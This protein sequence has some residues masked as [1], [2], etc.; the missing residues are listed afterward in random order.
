MDTITFPSIAVLLG[1]VRFLQ[2]ATQKDQRTRR[3]E[4]CG[5][6]TKDLAALDKAAAEG[7]VGRF[8]IEFDADCKRL[9]LKIPSVR[10]EIFEP[11]FFDV[12]SAQGISWRSLCPIGSGFLQS[13]CQSSRSK[14]AGSALKTHALRP[15]ES[16]PPTLVVECGVSESICRCCVRM[17][18]GG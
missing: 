1:A 18:F 17:R 10:H 3:L 8:R 6:S 9:R 7:K 2:E 15:R 14:E 11:T 5:L 4:V 16:D 13:L 12:L